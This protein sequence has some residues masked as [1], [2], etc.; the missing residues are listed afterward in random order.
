MRPS[1]LAAVFWLLACSVGCEVGEPP[2]A[3]G[4]NLELTR[5]A[6]QDSEGM[7]CDYRAAAC[8]VPANRPLTFQFNRWL[9]PSTATRQSISLHADQAT[10]AEFTLPKYELLTRTVTYWSAGRAVS[11]ARLRARTRRQ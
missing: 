9:L 8:G 4:E 3:L 5:Y 7:D 1:R 11:R 10:Y 6:P 2:L